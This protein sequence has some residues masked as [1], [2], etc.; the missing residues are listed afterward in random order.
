MTEAEDHLARTSFGPQ[1]IGTRGQVTS[2][3][4][5]TLTDRNRP[6]LGTTF[7]IVWTSPTALVQAAK[8]DMRGNL[9]RP[10]VR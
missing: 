9:E 10:G 4:P 8:G 2:Q 3:N 6:L 7:N 1:D 5:M